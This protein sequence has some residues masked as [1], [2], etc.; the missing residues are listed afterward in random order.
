ADDDGAGEFDEPPSTEL[1]AEAANRAAAAQVEHA[2]DELVQGQHQAARDR[3]AQ[4]LRTLPR[5]RIA[6]SL[7]HVAQAGLLQAE[8]KPVEAT[9]PLQPALAHAPASELARA[10]L[11]ALR[12]KA[13]KKASLFG[14][15]FSR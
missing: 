6:R 9:S 7:Y 15:L 1:V 8:G 14:R 11:G 3:L 4:V 12:A 2:R 13:D 5:D 10:A